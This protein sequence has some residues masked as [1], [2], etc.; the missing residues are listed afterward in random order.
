ME[1]IVIADFNKMMSRPCVVISTIS[2]NGVS[3]AAPFSFNS[4]ATTKPPMYGFCCEVE[5][6]TWRNIQEND[7]FVVNLVDESF[8]ELMELLARDLPYEISEI[9]EARL[10]EA[11]SKSVKPPRIQEA[12]GWIEC[13]MIK[14]T[15][16]SDK[17]VWIFGEVLTSEIKR[18]SF[19]EVV[20]VELV[21][22][23]NHIWGQEFVVAFRRVQ[24]RR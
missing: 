23:L 3:N 21:N 5:H 15:E 24:Y 10:T 18:N 13:R 8:G 19:N 2:K 9:A 14:Y 6:D 12:Y 11:P 7:E 22:P 1:D 16:L 17:I 20:D 4:P